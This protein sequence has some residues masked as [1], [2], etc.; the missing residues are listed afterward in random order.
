MGPA[1]AVRALRTDGDRPL[2]AAGGA[3]SAAGNDPDAPLLKRV[4]KGDA[5]AVE[6]LVERHAGRMLTLARRMLGNEADAEDVTQE[7]FLRVWRH[8]R[9]WQP[10]RARFETWMHRVTLNLCYDRLRRRRDVAVDA[11]PELPDPSPSVVSRQSSRQTAQRVQAELAK[12][13]DRQRAAIVLCHHEGLSNIEAAAVLQVSVEALESL[14]ARG[15]RA[16]KAALSADARE[17]LMTLE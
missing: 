5:R 1:G 10:G 13:P 17:L 14:L 6:L 8:A 16:L 12:L 2:A 11:L 9:R 15:R 4:A 7:L 3:P